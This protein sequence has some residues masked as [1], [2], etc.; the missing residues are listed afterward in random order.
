MVWCSA[1]AGAIDK[2]PNF[3]VAKRMRHAWNILSI[4][5]LFFLYSIFFPFFWHGRGAWAPSYQVVRD[6]GGG[7]V[8]TG[9][10]GYTVEWRVLGS[11]HGRQAA[12]SSARFGGARLLRRSCRD[13]AEQQLL[14]TGGRSTSLARPGSASV[15]ARD[16][17]SYPLGDSESVTVMSVKHGKIPQKYIFFEND[18][19]MLKSLSFSF[20][21]FL[22][23]SFLFF[24]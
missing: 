14:P 17:R 2:T 24:R 1:N 19:K 12:A 10:V 16:R 23:F 8:R 7:A 3:T 9:G 13:P 4:V 6:S 5:P 18:R 21:Y 15:S 22:L 11:E 20:S